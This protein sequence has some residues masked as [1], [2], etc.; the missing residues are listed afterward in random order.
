LAQGTLFWTFSNDFKAKVMY[1][2]AGQGDRF[3]K[4]VYA[5]GRHETPHA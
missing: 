5:L 4:L 1:R 3:E 2:L